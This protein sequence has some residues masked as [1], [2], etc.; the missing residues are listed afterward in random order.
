MWGLEATKHPLWLEWMWNIPTVLDLPLKRCNVCPLWG[1]FLEQMGSDMIH[2]LQKSIALSLSFVK[3]KLKG[4][5]S[6]FF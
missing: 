6:L 1:P 3:R 2:H 5:T 4:G